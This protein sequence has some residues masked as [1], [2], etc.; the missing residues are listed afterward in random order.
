M[1]LVRAVSQPQRSDASPHVG[2]GGILADTSA[3]KGLHGAVN[4]RQSSLGNENLGL[5]DFL[6]GLLWAVHIH[7]DGGVEDAA[8][9]QTALDDLEASSLAKDHV[10]SRH[11]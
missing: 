3:T 5:R 8:G 11:T 7:L 9:S 10:G 4:D 6:E 1:H 2:E